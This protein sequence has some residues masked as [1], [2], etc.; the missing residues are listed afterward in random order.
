MNAPKI[1]AATVAI[2]LV[3]TA[4]QMLCWHERVPEGWQPAW[5]QSGLWAHAGILLLAPAWLA[6]G[7]ASTLFG[8]D[9]SVETR[10]AFIAVACVLYAVAAYFIVYMAARWIARQFVSNQPKT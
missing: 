6:A 10:K 7:A 1:I 4:L 2:F 3:L 5:W 8:V 9:D